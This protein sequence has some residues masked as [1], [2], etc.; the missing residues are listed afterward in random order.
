MKQ[1]LLFLGMVIILTLTTSQTPQNKQERKITVSLTLS[2][3]NTVLQG[4]NE[5]PFKVSSPIINSIT[6]QAQAQLSD[7]TKT[8]K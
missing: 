6:M 5:M 7:T 2:D 8:K 4:L 1:V 3:W